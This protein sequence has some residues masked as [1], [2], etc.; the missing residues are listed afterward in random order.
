MAEIMPIVNGKYDTELV[1]GYDATVEFARAS[2]KADV[3]RM[4]IT[5][6]CRGGRTTLL[7][8]E[9]QSEAQGGGC[10]VRSRGRTDQRIR[11]A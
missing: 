1:S 6:F 4:G 9:I 10:V 7:D 11:A 3:G 5:G 8:A 2:R